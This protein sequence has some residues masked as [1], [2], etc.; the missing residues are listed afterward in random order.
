MNPLP[1]GFKFFIWPEYRLVTPSYSVKLS[2][3]N[4]GRIL[5]V[6]FSH[7]GKY[8]RRSEII[9]A[10]WGDDEDG[11]PETVNNVISVTIC[12]TRRICRAIGISFDYRANWGQRT[13]NAVIITNLRECD[14]YGGPRWEYNLDRHYELRRNKALQAKADELMNAQRLYQIHQANRRPDPWTHNARVEA[15]SLKVGEPV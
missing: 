13:D 6:L 15:S 3:K 9:D 11:G 5:A 4:Q 10:V 12:N 7:Y 8:V 2:S 1:E 14:P